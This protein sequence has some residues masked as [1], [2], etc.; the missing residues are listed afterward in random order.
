MGSRTV[1]IGELK[2]RTVLDLLQ[3]VTRQREILRVILESG[4]SVEIRP[5][6]LLTELPVLE[7]SVPD[8]WK[9]AIYGGGVDPP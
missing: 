3:Q 9:D 8:G 7:G 6:A 5:T 1:T 2:E 4:E